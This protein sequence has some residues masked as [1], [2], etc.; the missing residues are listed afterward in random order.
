MKDLRSQVST[1]REQ[2]NQQFQMFNDEK[3]KWENEKAVCLLII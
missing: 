3:K 1:L 2:L